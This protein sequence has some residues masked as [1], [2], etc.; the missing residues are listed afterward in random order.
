MDS[1]S[2]TGLSQAYTA[3]LN[4]KA[5]AG[6]KKPRAAKAT[7][8]RAKPKAKPTAKSTKQNKSTQQAK[9]TLKV[10]VADNEPGFFIDCEEP[11]APLSTTTKAVATLPPEPIQETAVTLAL[12]RY[13]LPVHHQPTNASL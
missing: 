9:S 10:E 6:V 5:Q 4:G 7:K 11:S 13:D 1:S 3:N 8:P 12:V 2:L